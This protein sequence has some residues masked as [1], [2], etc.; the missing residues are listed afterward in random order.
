LLAIFHDDD[1]DAACNPISRNPI[2]NF[3]SAAAAAIDQQGCGEIPDW[4]LLLALALSSH[5]LMAVN[6]SAA[7][8]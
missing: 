8:G 5:G 7:H 1:D 2:P 3:F 4:I 6:N